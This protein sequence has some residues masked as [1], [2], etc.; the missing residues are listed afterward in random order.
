MRLLLTSLTYKDVQPHIKELVNNLFE[1]VPAGVGSR[2]FVKLTA[3]EFRKAVE[4]GSKWCIKNGYGWEEDLERTELNGCMEGADSSKIS[5]KAIDRGLN[6]IGT[7]GSG[8][9]YCEIQHVKEENIYDKQ[10]AKRFGIFPDQ[11]VVMFHCLPGNTKILTEHGYWIEVEKLA[12]KW[13]NIKVKSMS[14]GKHTVNNTSIL[15]FFELKPCGRIFKITTKT[16]K[17]IVATEEH[18]IL[19]PNGLKLMKN[20]SI[21]DKVAI[22]PFDGVEYEEPSDK[23]IINEEDIKKIGGSDRTIKNLKKR[24][25]LPLRLNS[26]KFPI[27]VKLLGFLT[28]DGWL[29][30]VK[31]RWSLK[32]IGKPENLEEIRQDILELGYKATKPAFEKCVSNIEFTDG[33]VRTISG[34]TCS[35]NIGSIGLPM[36]FYVMGA[37]FGN[38]SRIDYSVPNWLFE[39]PLWIKRLYLGGYFGAEMTKLNI[40]KKEKFRFGNP[41]VSLNKLEKLKSSGYYFLVQIG[42]LLEEFGVKSIKIT[43]HTGVK[44]KLGGNT[45]KLRLKISSERDNLITLWSKIGYEYCKDRKIL[46]CYGSQ[47]LNLMNKLL[48]REAQSVNKEINQINITSYKYRSINYP[49]FNEFISNYK[50]NPPT[51]IIWDEIENKEEIKD[52]KEKVYDF[53]VLHED[54]N[55]IANNFVVGNC[56]SRGFGHQV[57]T[58]YLQL[59][60]KVMEPKYNIKIL[61]RELACAPFNS[62]EGQ[63]YFSAMKC[64][65][66]MSFANRQTIL[67]RIREVFSKIFKQD[68]EKLGMKMVFDISHNRASLEKHNI[69]GNEK[70][71]IVHRKGA[72]A[73]YGPG[74]IEIPKLYKDIGIPVIIGGSMQTG[75]YLLIGTESAK[76]TFYST[77]H[78][79]GRTM[80][81]TQARHMIRGDKLQKDMEQ[82]GIYVKT[83]SFSGLAEEA[84]F[85]YKDIDEVIDAANKAGISKPVVKLIP[86]GNVKGI[87]N[88]NLLGSFLILLTF[89]LTLLAL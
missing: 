50:L 36:L 55:F 44:T 78:G 15:K 5:N 74:R 65:V 22:M 2:G 8:N 19:T 68:A 10:L 31:D 35:I 86:L 62:K 87:A 24:G 16:G 17:K 69:D 75:S 29:G 4:E 45:I 13:K 61:D 59:F 46:S 20:I 1:R 52:F 64:G 58:D 84:G 39:S 77:C 66:N 6:Q 41:T 47:Y 49:T 54:H 82:K 60:L 7:L 89:L 56:G 21:E 12:K 32:F 27:L 72:T 28:G 71:V 3:N 34:E 85:A 79:S 76:E 30:K 11:I 51:P 67:H 42:K 23:I 40:R 26:E 14:V 18:P 53:T 43:E 25:L 73:S 80:S 70:E 63:D 37:P 9:H 83:T 81:R 88:L 57:A 33:K 38:K 48:G